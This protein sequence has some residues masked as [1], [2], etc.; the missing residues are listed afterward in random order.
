MTKTRSTGA[1]ISAGNNKRFREM[2]LEEQIIFYQNR[3]SELKRKQAERQAD[4]YKTV[5]RI[6]EEVFGT[7]TGTDEEIIETMDRMLQALTE[8]MQLDSPNQTT[9]EPEQPENAAGLIPPPAA[10]SPAGPN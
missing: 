2:T 8:Y 3:A 4:H 5:G 9:G 10:P 6:F 1:I 7:A